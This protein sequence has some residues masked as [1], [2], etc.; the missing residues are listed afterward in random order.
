MALYLLRMGMPLND[1][2]AKIKLD[3]NNEKRH[4]RMTMTY[5]SQ[6]CTYPLMLLAKNVFSSIHTKWKME[7]NGTAD[8]FLCDDYDI[9]RIA[10]TYNLPK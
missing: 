2:E 5:A 9:A 6:R 4:N 7:I 10:F 1:A 8:E 3:K